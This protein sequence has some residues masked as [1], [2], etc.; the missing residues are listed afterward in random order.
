M[1]NS[2]KPEIYIHIPFCMRKCNYCD[3]V[4]MACEPEVQNRYFDMLLNEISIKSES[5]GRVPIG[6]VFIGGGTPSIVSGHNIE[7]LMDKLRL[8][9]DI[10]Q[11][12]EITIEMNPASA[13]FSK[14]KTYKNVGIN[15]V[16]IG[17]QSSD[18]KE[19][20]VLGR[21]HSYEEFLR[22]YED[23][24]SAGVENVNIDLMSAIPTQTVDSY[25]RT[26]RNVISLKPE[27]ISAYSLIIEEGT[28]FYDAYSDGKGLPSED[29]E[30]EMY[31]LTK[32][33]LNSAGYNRYEISNYSKTGYECRHNIGYWRRVPYLGFGIAA[34]SLWNDVRYDHGKDIKKYLE[35][36]F[37]EEETIL[38]DQDI[39]EEFMFLGLRM[40]NGVSCKEFKEIFGTDIE[41]EYGDVLC[42]L[43]KEGLLLH[44]KRVRLTDKG[45]DLA[46]YCMSEFL[47]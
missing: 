39:M 28:P 6:S 1:K 9:F 15:R 5:V 17:L 16:S 18:N 47:H 41:T 24:R 29:E 42:K 4:S 12:A 22:T 21:L 43:A 2:N 13:S 19:L 3:F 32:E 44:G 23:V 27:H 38:S 7:R 40:V 35:G 10:E 25:V 26:L 46:N 20:K 30:R 8:K 34:S 45:L 33:L 37:T 11:S 14:I 31:Y 36:D